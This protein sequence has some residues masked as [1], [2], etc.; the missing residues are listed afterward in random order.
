MSRAWW[1][2]SIIPALRRLRQE[3]FKFETSLGYLVR[4]CL[5]KQNKTKHKCIEQ[6]AHFLCTSSQSPVFLPQQTMAETIPE[7]VC[8][9]QVFLSAINP[10]T[11]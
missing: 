1:Y 6:K 4:P 11:S 2:T 8:M 7:M 3:N 5:K 10:K 9:L